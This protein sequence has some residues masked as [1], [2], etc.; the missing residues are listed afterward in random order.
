MTVSLDYEEY[1]LGSKTWE[2]AEAAFADAEF[3]VLPCGSVEQHSIHLPVSVD[4]LRAENL[5]RELVEAAADRDLSMVRLPTLPY[6]YSEHHMSYPGTVTLMPDTYQQVLED[7]GASLAEH[8]VERLL[9]VNCHGGNR[10]P[11]KLAAD[12]IQRDHGVDV[13]PVHWTNYAR[14]QLEEKFDGDWGHAGDHETSFTE[15]FHPN[16]VKEEK[17]ESQTQKADFDA[18]QY[19]YFGDITDQGGTGDP[20]NSDPEFM[21]QVVADTSER[22]LDA[23]ES[24]LGEVGDDAE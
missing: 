20:T 16:L 2:D 8:G 21:E 12:R 17:K 14:E 9:F 10:S 3:V 15:L 23:L 18:R 7:V 19:E 22:I 11:M 6:G 13:Y 4:T 1:D 24:D 5:T